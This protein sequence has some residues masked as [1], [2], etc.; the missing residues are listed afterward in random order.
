[1]DGWMEGWM[2][3]WTEEGKDLERD[4]GKVPNRRLTIETPMKSSVTVKM[5]RS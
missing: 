5:S 1:M 3:G 4:G 2:D